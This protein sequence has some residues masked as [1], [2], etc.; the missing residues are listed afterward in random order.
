MIFS[1]SQFLDFYVSIYIY[2]KKSFFKI[3]FL[4]LQ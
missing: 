4:H 2:F 1:K 3:V